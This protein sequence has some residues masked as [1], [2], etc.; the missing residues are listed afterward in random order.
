MIVF[1]LVLRG[2][3]IIG[4][5]G[6]LTQDT[7]ESILAIAARNTADGT[8]L[9]PLGKDMLCAVMNAS[10]GKEGYTF[11]AVIQSNE[12]RD[13][14]FNFLDSVKSFLEK[15]ISNPRMKSEQNAFLSKHIKTQ[16][17]KTNSKLGTSGKLTHI[18]QTIEQATDKTRATISRN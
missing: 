11:V 4:E 3:T 12:E 17:E 2:K 8:R 16:M 6:N 5:F 9:V 7:V 18:N 15:E 1:S 10:V 13:I 14:S